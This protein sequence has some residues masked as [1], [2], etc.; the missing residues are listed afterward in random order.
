MS[1]A[2]SPDRGMAAHAAP[3]WYDWSEPTSVNYR[4]DDKNFYGP[5]ASVRA[6]MDY[7]FHV[8]YV[9]DRQAIQDSLI[10]EALG[11][12]WGLDQ[13]SNAHAPWMVFT[14]GAMGAGKSHVVD[15]MQNHGYLPLANLVHIDPD[16]VRSR[17]PE[18]Q[19][20]I[21]QSPEEAGS[22][23]QL[24]SGYCVEILQEAALRTRRN[25]RVDGSLRNFKWYTR[26]FEDIRKRF[27]HYR[28][29]IL[30]IE[31][32]T[33]VVLSRARSRAAMTKRAIP[34]PALL[35][36]IA[37][38]PQ[39]AAVLGPQA[40]LFARIL[41]E[42]QNGAPVLL[43]LRS[44]STAG[45]GEGTTTGV[46]GQ[47]RARQAHDEDVDVESPLSCTFGSRFATFVPSCDVTT[48]GN[49]QHGTVRGE[50]RVDAEAPASFK[51]LARALQPEPMAPDCRSRTDD[52]AGKPPSEAI[53]HDRYARRHSTH[54]VL[55]SYP[56]LTASSLPGGGKVCADGGG[57][58][59]PSASRA[60]NADVGARRRF[61]IAHHP[62]HTRGP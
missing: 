31:A 60:T 34:Q 61:S 54:G 33:E 3:A 42:T 39:A 45:G 59:A 43:E 49:G 6:T 38:I 22:R 51:D 24:E 29:A 35:E 11:E 10:T 36:A 16:A 19:Q 17:L 26:V 18:W 4:S 52:M 2:V 7:D 23:T 57:P 40:D 37:A 1:S 25:I 30:L 12:R 46:R 53:A 56:Q 15:W 48:D 28:I 50:C 58:G 8:N 62:Q 21:A 32:P 20:Y 44:D 55:C 5:Y 27:P 14:C 9:R 47:E 13:A 41:N